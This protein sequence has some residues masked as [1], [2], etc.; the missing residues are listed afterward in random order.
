MLKFR[1]TSNLITLGDLIALEDKSLITMRNIMAKCLVDDN[2]EAVPLPQAVERLNAVTLAD[3]SD[4]AE[5]FRRAMEAMK[6]SAI[7]PTGS[8]A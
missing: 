7:P 8:G 3:L 6:T 4:T 2:G 1:I 5:Q